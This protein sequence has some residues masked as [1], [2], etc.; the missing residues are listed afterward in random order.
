METLKYSR[1]LP[2]RWNVDVA[3]IGGGMAGVCAA[4]AAADSG[5]SV[6]LVERFA[7]T[8]GVMTNGGVNNFSGETGGQGVIFDEILSQLS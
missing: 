3:V 4:A 6:A 5:A 7:T 1:E 2:V 8:G